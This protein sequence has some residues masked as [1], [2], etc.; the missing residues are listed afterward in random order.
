MFSKTFLVN[1]QYSAMLVF[2]VL[3]LRITSSANESLH[4]TKQRAKVY[5]R[6]LSTF[7]EHSSKRR[8]HVRSQKRYCVQIKAS[9]FS[10]HRPRV[11]GH[12]EKGVHTISTGRGRNLSHQPRTNLMPCQQQYRISSD[13]YAF[14]AVYIRN[15]SSDRRTQCNER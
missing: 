11:Q 12:S 10:M 13:Y 3:R 8:R 4:R 1:S 6:C 14:L 9:E 15:F 5:T 2:L 7:D